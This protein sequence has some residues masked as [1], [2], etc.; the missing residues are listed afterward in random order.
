MVLIARALSRHPPLLVL[1][2]PT[3]D[4]DIGNQALV[5]SHVKALS[6][7]GFAVIMSTH[8]PSQAY[9]HSNRV[10]AL[11]D[12]KVLSI[13]KPENVISKDLLKKLYNIDSKITTLPD[14]N[15][16]ITAYNRKEIK[17]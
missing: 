7:E 9:A 1:D 5:M 13:G 14:G 4:L 3:S 16:H 10:L 17:E 2:E 11:C 15:I 8:D 6:D 12:G